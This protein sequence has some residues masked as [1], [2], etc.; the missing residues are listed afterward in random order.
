V[1]PMCGTE[2]R[3]PVTEDLKRRKV[4]YQ[5]VSRLKLNEGHEL[6]VP[7]FSHTPVSTSG[8]TEER[9]YAEVTTRST[10]LQVVGSGQVELRRYA[11]D[12]ARIRAIQSDQAGMT[13]ET[14]SFATAPPRPAWPRGPAFELSFRVRKGRTRLVVG[15][16]LLAVSAALAWM[17]SASQGGGGFALALLAALSGIL[18]LLTLTGR[19]GKP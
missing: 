4:T 19:V 11:Q 3:R 13:T 1:T 2:S 18:G 14:V 10:R 8:G 16:G 5:V 6:V 17:A 7:I 15:A 12:T 9:R